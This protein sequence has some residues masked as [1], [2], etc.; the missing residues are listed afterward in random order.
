MIFLRYESFKDYLRLYPVT[1]GLI[2]LNI[3]YFIVVVL[4]GKL[5]NPLHLYQ[6]G[7]F[8]NHY[9]AD[10]FGLSEPWRYLSSM[11]MHGSVDHL[12]FNMFAL[13][14]FAPPL[15]YL[16]KSA[17]YLMLYLLSGIGGNVLGALVDVL[18]KD[19]HARLAVGASGAIYG[20]YGAYLFIALYRKSMLDASSIKTVYIILAFGVVY[21][22][23]IPRVDLWGHVGGALVGF[24]LY[25]LMD[26]AKMWKRRYR[27]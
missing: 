13:I 4:N 11:F 23:I 8:I 3:I 6:F 1:A 7:A 2:V 15:E 21:S 5:S 18:T 22:V 26:R 9:Q 27:K 20:I 12:L 24:A 19:E 10:P 17:R 14:V 25:A 16:L